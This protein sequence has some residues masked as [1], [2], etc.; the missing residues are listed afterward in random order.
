MIE[1]SSV[2]R[3]RSAL[4]FPLSTPLGPLALFAMTEEV[5]HHLPNPISNPAFKG[6]EM[7]KLLS[8]LLAGVIAT[9]STT[10]FAQDKKDAA[11]AASAPAAAKADAP[12]KAK[13]VKKTKKAKKAPA[14]KDEAKK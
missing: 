3:A 5:A 2:V 11:P 1:K 7:N 12:K 10:A 9:V 14:A 13:K 8:V 6:N 4:Q